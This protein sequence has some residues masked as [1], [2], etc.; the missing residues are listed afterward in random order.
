MNK[1]LIIIIATLL[2]CSSWNFVNTENL[3]ADQIIIEYCRLLNDTS[4]CNRDYISIDKKSILAI[5]DTS[6]KQLLPS[7]SF[8][9]LIIKDGSAYGYNNGNIQTVAAININNNSN[10]RLLL[11]LDYCESATNFTDLFLNVKIQKNKETIC[12]AISDF[13]LKTKRSNI[14][15]CDSI[16][17]SINHNNFW[18]NDTLIVTTE[19]KE[20]CCEGWVK[21]KKSKMKDISSKVRTKFIF[22]NNVLTAIKYDE[23]RK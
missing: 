17:K 2:F 1:R 9:Y 20:H 5:N 12:K 8:Y 18:K 14:F 15:C 16:L 4:S 13:F 10:V 11:P 6:L 19:Y 23:W 3:P 7:I 21:V 22:N